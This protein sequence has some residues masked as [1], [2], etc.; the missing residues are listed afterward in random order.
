MFNQFDVTMKNL[1]ERSPS[2]WLRFAGVNAPEA[3]LLEDEDFASIDSDLTT[4][5]TACDKVFRISTPSPF[6]FHLEFESEGKN[7]PRRVLRYS[8]LLEYKHELPVASVAILLRKSADSPE[9]NGVFERFR[10][11]GTCYL[12]FRYRVIR[13]WE[14]PVDQIL[15][16][17]I[18][19]LPLA[20]IS[21]VSDE[22]LPEVLARMEKRVN[23][24][25]SAEDRSE[26]WTSTYLMMGLQFSQ[27]RS[28]E[29]LKGVAHMTN[30]TTY[31]AIL[32]EG[33]ARGEAQG[34]LKEARNMI[35]LIGGKRLG[36]PGNKTINRLNAI[37]SIEEIESLAGRLEEVE[38]W[39]EL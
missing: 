32:E 29:L 17:E 33:E 34:R 4:I 31:M 35:F 39:D 23:S 5:T 3:V 2:A 18:G 10:S 36:K 15:Q 9:I 7:V 16:G 38:N 19:I 21:L 25:L 8:V 27:K 28:L 12:H 13:I 20:P 6:L 24:E 37:M 11:D 26:F 14:I 1:V 30:S 22:N